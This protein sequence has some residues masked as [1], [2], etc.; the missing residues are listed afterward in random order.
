MN[1]L[2]PNRIS[3]ERFDEIAALLVQALLRVMARKSSGLCAENADKAVDFEGVQ[4]GAVADR[5]T[6]NAL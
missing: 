2:S 3:H 1:A 5:V 4:S 6:E